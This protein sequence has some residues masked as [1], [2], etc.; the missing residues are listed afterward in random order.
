[1]IDWVD[2]FVPLKHEFG[3]KSPFYAGE[4]L[5][6]HG[7]SIEW[8]V[9]KRL[10]MEGSYSTKIQVQSTTHNHRLGI[11]V[12]GNLVKWHQG[13]NVFGSNDLRAIV[14]ASLCRIC[15]ITNVKPSLADLMAWTSGKAVELFRVDVTE[16]QD[17][18]SRQRVQ[19]ALRAL[20]ASAHLKMRGR[21][22]YYGDSL[23]FGKGSRHWSLTAYAK[24]PEIDKHP[25]PVG[26][27]DSPLKNHADGLL[28]LEVRMLSMHL[29]KLGL[30]S[31]E[32]WSENTASEVH[33]MHLST[34]EISDSTMI[35]TTALDA[36]PARLKAVYQ[37]WKEGHD[38]RE[39]YPPRTFYRYR[40]ELLAQGIDIAVKQARREEAFPNVIPLK[41]VLVAKSATIPDWAMGTPL[42]FNPTL[43][44][45]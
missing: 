27:H 1:M 3:E 32:R 5:A 14:L 29:K 4:V 6:M 39:L 11:R 2:F 38:L 19:A 35:D 28:R 25:L 41:V 40:K 20:D 31:L 17:L 34:L 30:A 44:A 7:D 42:Y 45:A 12:S 37:L 24:G 43:R 21:G 22:T 8:G 10:S 16:S 36:L 9:Y 26:L 15:E 18:G 13:H 23:L 33:Q